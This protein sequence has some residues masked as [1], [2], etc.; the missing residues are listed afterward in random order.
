M[1]SKASKNPKVAFRAQKYGAAQ[2]GIQFLMTFEEWWS[3][4]QI[5]N[6][7]ERRG[8][9]SGQLVMARDN[10]E[11]P[12][13]IDNIHCIECGGNISE[14]A[15]WRSWKAPPKEPKVVSSCSFDVDFYNRLDD[16]CRK[17]GVPMIGIIEYAVN[18]CF[19]PKTTDD[20]ATADDESEQASISA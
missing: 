18:W 4:W 6:R 8:R 2:R 5:D 13:H 17:H 15:M 7:W 3:W 14:G 20:A 19:G 11:G 12:Y 10:D 9:N 16:F 1:A